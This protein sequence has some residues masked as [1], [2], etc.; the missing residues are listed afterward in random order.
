LAFEQIAAMQKGVQILK[1]GLKDEP[2]EH[3]PH[4]FVVLGASVSSV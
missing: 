1:A 3:K 2:E 4:V